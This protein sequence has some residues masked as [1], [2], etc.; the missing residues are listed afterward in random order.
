MQFLV[1]Y[2]LHEIIF[3]R[4]NQEIKEGS[5]KKAA[6]VNT[7]QRARKTVFQVN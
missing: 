4:I 2:T 6:V 3:H 7:F 5:K 1:N